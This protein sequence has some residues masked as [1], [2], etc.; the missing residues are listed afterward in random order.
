MSKQLRHKNSILFLTKLLYFKKHILKNRNLIDFEKKIRNWPG[1]TSPD[2]FLIRA[3]LFHHATN[4]KVAS[5]QKGFHSCSNLQRYVQN[6]SPSPEP[7]FFMWVVLRGVIRH[8]RSV[9]RTQTS[10]F[11]NSFGNS[12]VIFYNM[13]INF[14][15]KVHIK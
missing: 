10:V 9:K 5:S 7:L 15:S 1:A 12:F 6:Y 8:S 3:K 13:E 14:F 2:Q 11:G 4:I